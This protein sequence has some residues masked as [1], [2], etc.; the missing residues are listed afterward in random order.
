MYSVLCSSS[1]RASECV[2]CLKIATFTCQEAIQ[3]VLMTTRNHIQTYRFIAT[4][5]RMPVNAKA[6]LV[7]TWRG[8]RGGLCDLFLVTLFERCC[9]NNRRRWVR[10]DMTN[11]DPTTATRQQHRQDGILQLINHGLQ[12]NLDCNNTRNAVKRVRQIRQDWHVLYGWQFWQG[13]QEGW[14]VQ[15]GRHVWQ[16]QQGWHVLHDRHF[17]HVDLLPFFG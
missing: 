8:T 1:P 7:N 16:V 5:Q 13:R 9:V 4:I 17:W 2:L 3:R 14:R 11:A 15:Q 10:R 6:K 12:C